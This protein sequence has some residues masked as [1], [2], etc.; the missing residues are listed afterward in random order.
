MQRLPGGVLPDWLGGS[1]VHALRGRQVPAL[2]AGDDVRVVQLPGRELP[3]LADG[4]LHGHDRK[5]CLRRVPDRIWLRE[6]YELRA[7]R[8]GPVRGRV[9]RGAEL[10]ELRGGQVPDR[11]EDAELQ[12]LRDGQVPERDGVLGVHELCGGFLRHRRRPERLHALQPRLVPDGGGHDRL[13]GLRLR[14]ESEPGRRDVLR[15]MHGGQDRPVLRPGEPVRGLPAGHVPVW[16]PEVGVR[17]VR[18]G[19]VPDRERED[20][21]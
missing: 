4:I 6:R 13:R 10:C 2:H 15:R 8:G 5:V 20:G 19:Q 16:G 17:P 9:H 1:G 12:Q 3:D 18:G 14:Q 11:A 7:V 21:L